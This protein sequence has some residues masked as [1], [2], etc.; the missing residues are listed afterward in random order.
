MRPGGDTPTQCP[1]RPSPAA[2]P[3]LT[4]RSRSTPG[5]KSF[6]QSRP[7][8]AARPADEFLP[9]RCRQTTNEAG[10]LRGETSRPLEHRPATAAT[11]TIAQRRASPRPRTPNATRPD[12]ADRQPAGAPQIGQLPHLGD[13]LGIGA[14]PPNQNQQGFVGRYRRVADKCL[15]TALRRQFDDRRVA[16]QAGGKARR[17]RRDFWQSPGPRRRECHAWRGRAENSI[18]GIAR[19]RDRALAARR[20]TAVAIEGS[21]SSRKQP[22]TC[23][24]VLC[25]ATWSTQIRNSARPAG[26]RVPW[27]MISKASKAVWP[28]NHRSRICRR[29]IRVVMESF[30]GPWCGRWRMRWR[31]RLRRVARPRRRSTLVV[32]WTPTPAAIRRVRRCVA[33]SRRH[34]RAHWQQDPCIRI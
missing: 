20:S 3:A 1:L 24:S 10:R 28:S 13:G 5:R 31:H 26:S 12:S 34:A 4:H 9:T 2:D 16:A 23:Q 25:R 14:A 32:Y 21:A 7:A 22:V 18:S 30:A 11:A 6:R 19:M 15:P 33:G 29:R 8:P 17:R 27:P